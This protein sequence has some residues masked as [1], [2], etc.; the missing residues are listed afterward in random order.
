MYLW[1]AVGIFITGG[2][3]MWVKKADCVASYKVMEFIIEINQPIKKYWA[4]KRE[5]EQI[6]KMTFW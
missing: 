6:W 5:K 1:R 4:L 2:A 3:L